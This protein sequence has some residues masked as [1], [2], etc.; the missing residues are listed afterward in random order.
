M[1]ASLAPLA[2]ASIVLG[3]APVAPP[4]TPLRVTDVRSLSGRWVGTLIDA[5]NMGTPVQIVI[6][7]DATYSA[8]FGDTSARGTVAL[9]PD[10]Q[11]AFTMTDAAGLLSLAEASSTA[12]LYDRGGAR[13]LVGNGRVGLRERPFSYEVTQQR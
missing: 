9:R 2:V 12:V 3:C 4:G 5:H 11:L 7:P 1:S 10:G 6:N 13:V 8:R